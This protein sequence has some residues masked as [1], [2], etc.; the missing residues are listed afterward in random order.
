MP[1]TARSQRF[2]I[3]PLAVTR[4]PVRMEMSLAAQGAYD[5]LWL[6]SWVAKE[7]GVLSAS[8]KMLACLAQC[9]PDEWASVRDMV[10]TAFTVRDATWT[11]EAIKRTLGEQDVWRDQW[12]KRKR[13][14]R[15]RQRDTSVTVHGDGGRDISGTVHDGTGTGTGSGVVQENL[16]VEHLAE[17]PL[18]RP[19]APAPRTRSKSPADLAR[20]ARARDWDE[21]FDRHFWPAYPRKVKKP[22][23]RAAWAKIGE[24]LVPD[25]AAGNKLLGR[26]LDALDDAKASDE[27]QEENGRFIP[28]PTSW[29]NA[30][31]WEDETP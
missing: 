27:W 2:L 30:Q 15:E 26:M 14:S 19:T 21:A 28:H 3:D 16:E 12:R 4:D 6:E 23:A 10:A 11:C 18:D 17:L 25:T 29:L 5:N 22:K 24:R 7:P 20:A 1:R 9:T 13:R 31:R 8:D